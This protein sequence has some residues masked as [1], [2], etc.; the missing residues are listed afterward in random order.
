MPSRFLP[1][2]PELE[3]TPHIAV[4]ASPS[5]H[6]LLAISNHPGSATPPRLIDD[7]AAE[8]VLRALRDPQACALIARAAAVTCP[9]FDAGALLAIWALLHPE[10]A[11]RRAEQIAGLAQGAE[12]GIAH[13]LDA[14]GFVCA[15]NAFRDPAESPLAATLAGRD[16]AGRGAALFEALLPQMPAMLENIRDFDLLWIGEYSDVL[17][18]DSLFNSG[19]VQIESVPELDLVVLDTPLRLHPLIGLTVSAGRSRLLTV[20]SENTYTLEYRYESWVQL[21]SWRPRPRINLSG[22]ATR[23]NMFERR[24]GRW[25]ADPVWQPR[26]RLWFDDGR[27]SA[28]PSSI[29]RETV[30]AEALD[31]LRTHAHDETLRWSPYSERR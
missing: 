4:N 20:R 11:L 28:S 21:R 27:G 1:P 13:D 23:L 25:R 5:A 17:Q 16:D 18:A 3:A 12:F 10:E 2:E 26:S 6:T 7:T 22:L 19:A 8:T 24:D 14:T 31:F 29:D 30:V 9:A 15:V